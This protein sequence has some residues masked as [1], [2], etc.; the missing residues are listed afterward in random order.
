MATAT[1]ENN[2]ANEQKD[3]QGADPGQQDGKQQDAKQDDK[4]GKPQKN[5]RKRKLLLIG[6]AVIVILAGPGCLGLV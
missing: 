5:P 6:L 4:S 2:A 1:T 3:A